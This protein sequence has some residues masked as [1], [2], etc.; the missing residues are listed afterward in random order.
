MR[1]ANLIACVL[2]IATC[3][4]G[5]GQTERQFQNK[6]VLTADSIKRDGPVMHLDGNVTIETDQIVLRAD[7][8]TFNSD[9]QEIQAQGNVSVK[10]KKSVQNPL[11]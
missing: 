10:L 4:V 5:V 3:A 9:S 8:A 11:F 7:S 6:Q 1:R 2:A